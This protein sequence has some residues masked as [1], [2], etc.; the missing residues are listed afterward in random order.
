MH[1][2]ASRR[3]RGA[4]QVDHGA[5][6]RESAAIKIVRSRSVATDLS[7][8]LIRRDERAGGWVSWRS[9]PRHFLRRDR[10]GR[11]FINGLARARARDSFI[12]AFRSPRASIRKLTAAPIGP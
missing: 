5:G 4:Q 9:R 10:I 3:R 8:E 7:R 12:S 11:E 1:G 2:A 6:T